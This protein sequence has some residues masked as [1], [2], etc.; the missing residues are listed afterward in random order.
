MAVEAYY[1]ENKGKDHKSELRVE[2]GCLW[3]YQFE[4]KKKEGDNYLLKGKGQELF[5][6]V[7]NHDDT[8]L[9]FIVNNGEISTTTST[10]I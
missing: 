2:S 9:H 3:R 10:K 4:K 8:G 5:K 7:N 1:L 6:K